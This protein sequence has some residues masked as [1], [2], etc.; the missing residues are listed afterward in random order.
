VRAHAPKLARAALHATSI[1]AEVAA[2]PAQIS[3]P[4]AGLCTCNGW[5]SPATQRPFR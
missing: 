1:S 4:V 2:V 5:P 3:A